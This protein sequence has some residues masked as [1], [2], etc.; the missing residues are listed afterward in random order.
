MALGAPIFALKVVGQVE[1][2]AILT[3]HTVADSLGTSD[4]LWNGFKDTLLLTLHRKAQSLLGGTSE[5]P[6]G[7]EKVRETLIAEVRRLMPGSF[8]E[9]ELQAHFAN[10]PAR[11]FEVHSVR[12]IFTDLTL[13]GSR[14]INSL[15]MVVSGQTSLDLGGGTL[16]LTSGGLIAS[17][18]FNLDLS[19]TVASSTPSAPRTHE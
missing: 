11:Y 9:D 1:T 10:L 14:T 8:S 18:A 2:L 17:Q 5:E 7:T 6:A 13:A 12:Q 3:L 19:T 4:K 15:A 16:N